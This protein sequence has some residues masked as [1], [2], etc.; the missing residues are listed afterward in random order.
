[1]VVVEFDDVVDS[2]FCIAQIIGLARVFSP[3][4]GG[5]GE[6]QEDNRCLVESLG[7]IRCEDEVFLMHFAHSFLQVGLEDGHL[8]FFALGDLLLVNVEHYKLV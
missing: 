4:F 5:G 2:T 8:A 1:M 3:G 6:R 7:N